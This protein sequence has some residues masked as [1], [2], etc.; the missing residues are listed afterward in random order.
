MG[1]DLPA[2]TVTFLFTDIEGSTRL[3]HDLGPERYAE[4]LAEHRRIL[5]EAFARHGGVEVD[6]QGD[7]FFVAF[8][9]A[10]GALA[11]AADAME[12]LAAGPIR[13]RAGIHTGTP[14]LG[15][16]GYVGPDVHMGA[17]IAALA[18]GGQVLLSASTRALVDADGLRDMGE[19]RLKDIPEP[20]RLYQLGTSEF[21]P[22]RSLHR[23]SI[24][25]APTTFVGREKELAA[26]SA[27]V[28]ESRL[29]T[30]TGPGG[31]GKTRLAMKIA[32]RASAGLEGGAWWVPLAP[33]R[34]PRLVLEEAARAVGA[35][36]DLATHIGDRSTLLLLDNFEQVVDAASAV[37]DL[38]AACPNLRI[39]VTSR[40]PLRLAGEREYRVPTLEEQAAVSLFLS[41]ARV[42]VPELAEDEAVR[43]ICR[44]LDH[45][46]LAIELAAARVRLLSP[47][48]ML[49]RLDR[50][51]PLLAGGARDLPERQRTL[52]AA[53]DWSYEL[54]SPEE[55]TLFAR[56]SVFRGSFALDT[57]E[58]AA[59]AEFDV[60]ASL[61]DKSLVRVEDER[62]SML[63]TIREY[64]GERLEASGEAAGVRLRHARHFLALALEAEPHLRGAPK[65]WWDRLEEVHDDL[66]AA[67]DRL[68]ALGE[69]QDAMA[70]A[71][72]LWRFWAVRGYGREGR[73]RIEALVPLDSRP[74]A[75]R[76]DML[77]GATG[78]ALDEPGPDIRRL[79]EEALAIHLQLGS[80]FGVANSIFL[81]GHV[82]AAAGDWEE[83]RDRFLESRRRFE[84]V[85]DE[86]YRL[87]AGRNLAWM[88]FELGERASA[89]ALTEENLAQARA[90]GNRRIAAQ[91]LGSLGWYD[92]DDGLLDDALGHLVESYGLSREDGERPAVASSLARLART[93]AAM[94]RAR[95]AARVLASAVELY[96][97]IGADGR[98]DEVPATGDRIR[99]HLDEAAFASAWKEGRGLTAEERDSLVS[100]LLRPPRP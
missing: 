27:L 51:L 82:A 83:G 28:E 58:S 74:T 13:V 3:L 35:R 89:R 41:R 7:A 91:S 65:A 68:V 46:P 18:H 81:L 50:R 64:A 93:L 67:L 33:V 20:Q 72:A 36:D 92:T 70:L 42:A 94:G 17:R 73:R 43:E 86:H 30:L 16:E 24:P 75:A 5:R 23:S 19:H 47:A 62:F 22:L 88:Y 4:A 60:L 6:T 54:L 49:E 87:L 85:G 79:A 21:A 55:R 26:L 90:S 80:P 9:T 66:R 69:I 76:A 71:G 10:P 56:L 31:T 48:R 84:E 1:R 61:V 29:V 96:E 32:A 14:Y 57:A 40:E 44:R 12:G 95:E 63:E 100:S 52:R 97:E 45:L 15:D 8:P 59:D 38:L 39:L 11:A 99:S 2:G 78:L 98:F 34:D 53:I 37:A 77:N 25:A